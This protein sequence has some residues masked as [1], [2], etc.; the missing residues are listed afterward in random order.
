MAFAAALISLG[1]CP[2]HYLVSKQRAMIRAND[3]HDV[4]R[5]ILAIL[6][7]AGE[8]SFPALVNSI[9]RSSGNP[10]EVKVVRDALKHLSSHDIVEFAQD[11]D[12][13]KL[14]WRILPV[15]SGKAELNSIDSK[16]VWSKENSIWKWTAKEPRLVVLLTPLGQDFSVSILNKYGW[17]MT[18]PKKLTPNDYDYDFSSDP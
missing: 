7:E 6:N 16:L 1:V 11:R 9:F 14:T 3:L 13:D 18:E 10:M 4:E 17:K 8:E 2:Y 5:R 15:A 12:E